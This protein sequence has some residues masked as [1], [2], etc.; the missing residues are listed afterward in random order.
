VPK[1]T[2]DEWA[3]YECL[4]DSFAP[5]EH[6]KLKREGLSEFLKNVHQKIT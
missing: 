6:D 3:I 5:D 4:K 1:L 2:N